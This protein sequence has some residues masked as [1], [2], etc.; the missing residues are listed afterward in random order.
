MMTN[1][2]HKIDVCFICH[3]KMWHE[4][5][6]TKGHVRTTNK[7]FWTTVKL[8]LLNG[9]SCKSSDGLAS[10]VHA[11]VC[12]S[13]PGGSISSSSFFDRRKFHVAAGPSEWLGL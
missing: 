11:G 4:A 9:V 10:V 5:I 6:V 13:S 12:H 3:R 8:A 2:D 7:I 1:D